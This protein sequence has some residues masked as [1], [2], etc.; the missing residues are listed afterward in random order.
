MVFMSRITKLKGVDVI[1]RMA[2]LL[3]S[4]SKDSSVVID[5]YGP[6]NPPEKEWFFNELDRFNDFVAYHGAL[7]PEQIFETLSNYDV[8]LFPTRYP[9][10]GCPGAVIDAYISGI[11]VIASDWKYNSEFVEHNVSGLIFLPEKETDF[12]GFILEL[13]DNS[14]KLTALKD[15]ASKKSREFSQEIAKEILVQHKII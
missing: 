10:E 5:F 4:Q 8:M 6:L 7:Q 13:I 2:E 12:Y 14:S 1:F 3:K 9:G 15:G 11:P